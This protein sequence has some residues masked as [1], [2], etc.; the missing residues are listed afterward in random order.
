MK[1][2]LAILVMVVVASP[3]IAQASRVTD[4]ERSCIRQAVGRVPAAGT[5][6]MVTIE[7]RNSASFPSKHSPGAVS[8]NFDGVI[9]VQRGSVAFSFSYECR[10]RQ[11]GDWESLHLVAFEKLD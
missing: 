8:H 1:R 7:S 10:A 9:K 6:T 11:E 4:L 5:E 3:V 2:L